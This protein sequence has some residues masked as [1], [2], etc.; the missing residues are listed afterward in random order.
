MRSLPDG[1]WMQKADAS[2]IEG[3]GIPSE[4]LM[5]RAA[6]GVVEFMEEQC[7]DKG[8]LLVVC[9]S[10]NNGGDG[11]AVARL[12][13]QKGR[14]HDVTVFFVGKEASMSRECGLQA[15]IAKNLGV[16]I[17]TEIPDGEYNIIID[18]VFG[19][20][21]S[22]EIGGRYAEVVEWMNRQGAV[23]L[24]IDIPSGIDARSGQVLPAFSI[25]S[26]LLSQSRFRL[27]RAVCSSSPY[28]CEKSS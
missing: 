21:L 7:L 12:L 19:V 27:Q 11:F 17:V 15:R 4:V 8:R 14:G 13:H 26:R 18:S 24:A 2:T 6:L 28:I 1:A 3:I 9:G 20:G 23:K 5:E 16:E 10:G 25:R 22:R